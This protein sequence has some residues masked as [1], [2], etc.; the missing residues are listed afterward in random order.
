MSTIDRAES[1]GIL[2]AEKSHDCLCTVHD[3]VHNVQSSGRNCLHSGFCFG[4]TNS[5]AHPINLRPS[6]RG[7][8]ERGPTEPSGPGVAVERRMEL[9][10]ELA[11]GH[12]EVD[13]LGSDS[14]I[15]DT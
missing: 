12:L 7:P 1:A 4:C 6:E 10:A 8:S 5:R 11:V 2:N 9:A 15:R 14:N 13:H 3:R